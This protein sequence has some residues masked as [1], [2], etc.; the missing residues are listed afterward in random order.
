MG[1][2]HR[3]FAGSGLYNI[4]ASTLLAGTIPSRV[5]TKTHGQAHGLVRIGHPD[6]IAIVRVSLNEDR[7]EVIS[8]GL[9]R[10]ARKI[11]KGEIFVPEPALGKPLDHCM[12]L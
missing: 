6:G 1:K 4:A 7:T 8:V 10:T 9:E 12:R 5:T 11:M 3:T 2:L